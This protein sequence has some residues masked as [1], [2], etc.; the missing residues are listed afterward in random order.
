[1]SNE[2]FKQHRLKWC[3]LGILFQWNGVSARKH[4]AGV[5][6]VKI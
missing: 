2:N 1:M 5:D 6:I 3:R 4:S